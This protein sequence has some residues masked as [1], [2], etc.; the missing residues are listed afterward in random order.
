[1]TNFPSPI[2]EDTTMSQSIFPLHH[3]SLTADKNSI[4]HLELA[5]KLVCDDLTALAMSQNFDQLMIESF[6]KFFDAEVVNSFRQ[7][8]QDQDFSMFP[9]IDILSEN[10]LN[11]ANGAF[12]KETN[13]IYLSQEF[14]TQNIEHPEQI[15]NLF[16]EEFGH[17]IDSQINNI[18]SAGDEGAIFSAL[19]QGKNLSQQELS[20]LKVED[21]TASILLNDISIQIEKQDP[22][23]PVADFL[24]QLESLLKKI[25][26][27]AGDQIFSGNGLPNLGELSGRGLPLLGDSLKKD[28][29]QFF[30]NTLQNIRNAIANRIGNVPD[31]LPDDLVNALKDVFPNIT[32]KR[33]GSKIIF[34]INEEKSYK[35]QADLPSDLNV[36]SLNINFRDPSTNEIASPKVDVD[37]SYLL[38]FGIGIDTAKLLDKD[39][40]NDV[41]LDISSDKELGVKVSPQ[42]LPDTSA[43]IGFMLVD[44]KDAGTK[45]DFSLNLADGND[46]ELQSNELDAL[47]ANAGG[48]ADIKIQLNSTVIKPDKADSPG[49]GD[50][51]ALDRIKNPPQ[52]NTLL[53]INWSFSQNAL[54]PYVSLED[55]TVNA[56]SLLQDF[57]YPIIDPIRKIT[58][59]FGKVYKALK[60]EVPFLG[61]INF[62]SLLEDAST[63]SLSVDAGIDTIEFLGELDE[64]LS[65]ISNSI[66]SVSDVPFNLGDVTVG[67]FDL[68]NLLASSSN[69]TPTGNSLTLEKLIDSIPLEG[70]YAPYRDVFKKINQLDPY[71]SLP[72][73]KDPTIIAST[74][75]GQ[76]Y[77]NTFPGDRVEFLSFD[78]PPLN[79]DI[80]SSKR[81]DFPGLPISFGL[82]G[83]IKAGLQLGFTYDSSG[84]E[85][86]AKTNFDLDQATLLA[87]GLVIDDHRIDNIDQPE[88][89]VTGRL[90]AESPELGIPGVLSVGLDGGIETSLIADLEDLGE[91]GDDL[92]DSDGQLRGTEI[93]TK[94]KA[95]D[96]DCLLELTGEVNAFLGGYIRILFWKKRKDF[97]KINL[98]RFEISDC[99][100]HN[101]ILA[102]E[103]S[104]KFMGG[105]LD[106]NAGPRA[107]KRVF[108]STI[109]EAETFQLQGEGNPTGDRITAVA[110]GS[111]QTFEGVT[112]IVGNMGEFDDTLTISNI[113]IPLE[114]SGG[115]GNDYL[116]GGES[117]DTLNGNSDNDALAGEGGNDLL[118][119]EDGNDLIEGGDGN[120]QIFG[121]NNS[122]NATGQLAVDELF[123]NAGSDFIDG[124]AGSDFIDGGADDD[125]LY[126]DTES[127]PVGND[128]LIGGQGNDT[129][130]GLGG[131]DI[132]IGGNVSELADPAGD[133]YLNGG[134]GDD[135][136]IGDLKN[137]SGN[138]FL[139]GEAGSDQITGGSGTDTVS[140]LS[141]PNGVVVNI[142]EIQGYTTETIES[143][144]SVSAGSAQD[145]FGSIDTF[146]TSITIDS[147]NEEDQ[148]TTTN[149]QDLAGELE[150]II[151]SQLN[152]VLIGNNQSNILSGLDGRDLLIGN[153]DDDILE[154]GDDIDTIS[155][156]RDPS[157]VIV[158]LAENT[159]IDGFGGLDTLHDIENVIGS[160]FDDILTGD[161][162]DNLIAAGKGNDWVS[163][164][165]GNDSIYGEA[166]H[167]YLRGEAGNDLI[168]GGE[169]TDT[170][171][172]NNSPSGVIVNIDETDSY[173]N[174]SGI[175]HTTIF[176]PTPVP[177]DTES[178]FEISPGAAYDGFGT[179]DTLQNLENLV[180]SDYDDILIGNSSI[181]IIEATSGNDVLIGNSGEDVLNGGEGSDTV[182][183][184]RDPAQVTVSLEQNNAI[185]GFGNTDT[186]NSIENVI[187]S[188]FDDNIVGDGNVN[189]IH[190]G[191]GSDRIE[192]RNGND[193]VFGEIGND[194]IL[195]EGGDDYLIGGI[196]ADLINGGVGIDTASYFT[197]TSKVTASLTTRRGVTGDARGDRFQSIEN[198]EGSQF[199]DRLIGDNSNNILSGLGGNDFLDGRSGDNILYGGDGSDRLLTGVGNDTLYGEAGND[200]LSSG[201]GNDFLDGGDGND[202]LNGAKGNDK[203]YG[204]AGDDSLV[205]GDGNDLLDGGTGEDTLEGQAGDD[206]L[207]GG[208]GDDFILG[209]EGI[210]I[211]Y[212]DAGDD[213]LDGGDGNDSLDGGVGDD[214]LH[215]AEGDDRLIGAN[216][217]DYLEGGAGSDRIFG[218][219]GD[220][221]LEGG[222]GN[223]TLAGGTGNDI[224]TGGGNNDTFII[225][226]NDSTDIITDFGGIGTGTNPGS[227]TLAEADILQFEGEGLTA[228]NML[229]T[230]QGEDL[231]ISF[232]GVDDTEVVL[233]NFALENLDNIGR[234]PGTTSHKGNIFFLPE[235]QVPTENNSSQFEDVFDVFNANWEKARVLNRN[236]VTF[237]NDLSNNTSGFNNSDD[238]INGL[239]GDD[240][241][242]GLS[243][244]DLLRGGDGNDTLIGGTG[245]N[246]LVGGTGA[247]QFQLSPSGKGIDTIQDFSAIDGD[248]ILIPVNGFSR[249]LSLGVLNT[250]NFTLGMVANRES[251]RLIYDT[252]TGA[253]YFDAD[254]IGSLGQTQIAQ[255]SGQPTLNQSNILVIA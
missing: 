45:F 87:N 131:N 128:T 132:L 169:S 153:G 103:G 35:I 92:G 55:I 5:G 100:D 9:K 90:F 240:I 173:L 59:P 48:K 77:K 1:M 235:A 78:L 31:A 49:S 7:K 79:L 211:L 99:P 144:F 21:D 203:L 154:G 170:V 110:F 237:L 140:Y 208:E 226:R 202:F 91:A 174:F 97:A 232:E 54:A 47:Q 249:A 123:G 141:S 150:N 23:V 93:L 192:V 37:I 108:V 220:D 155:Y 117:G 70:K 205:G 247:D 3:N 10:I 231:I 96:F 104:E 18:D 4:E 8:W 218:D 171:S 236:T 33:D 201:K 88:A 2:F 166:G 162:V 36:K 67:N 190:A 51:T 239:A 149:V 64:F 228:R 189:I 129:L 209:D 30:D 83:S 183:Y 65:S 52:A 234:G 207:Y 195:G 13:T 42:L 145:G 50:N 73:L 15:S 184:R 152:D 179:V 229:L 143:N 223:D 219:A 204:Q 159:A 57:L 80:S 217:D 124:G 252:S 255:L 167:D 82:G 102:N 181:N 188:A 200:S 43:T 178:N 75:L 106:L 56:G 187:G 210:D 191:E 212:G 34:L 62:I 253:L 151:G 244:N 38:N 122:E 137:E 40:S 139:I 227:V 175:T 215:G 44:A 156:Y 225:Q 198:L 69:A 118:F 146:H 251:D 186:L 89:Q 81:F 109:D 197:S 32:S 213:D 161:D 245:A 130:Q 120:D 95:T 60:V 76:A 148:S 133:D 206:Q 111:L 58:E 16:L 177:T 224:L 85:Q 19:S 53:N 185:D 135:Q 126:G 127:A 250:E 157:M 113:A 66:D 241:L 28:N 248:R 193:I 116:M 24:N 214:F 242:N 11:G 74:F 84:L 41:F 142:D 94:I 72:I 160:G 125:I 222:T 121:G 98:T 199:N 107:D 158:N 86:W 254:G 238:V 233:Q 61:N 243:G 39:S 115:N 105:S 112:K 168:N 25:E 46:N 164:S 230:Q 216:G 176:V 22:K 71:L 134:S 182:S 246:I 119:G 147:F 101:P 180:G 27:T 163:S 196:G 12:A 29:S 68:R 63:G 17:F 136:L 114:I 172:Y 194:T 165:G 6:G 221:N 20:R 14:I 26:S 138:D